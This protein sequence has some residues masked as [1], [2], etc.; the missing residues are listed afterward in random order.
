MKRKE[1]CSDV[2]EGDR[3]EGG[4]GETAERSVLLSE[5]TADRVGVGVLS[6][7]VAPLTVSAS[8]EEMR[9]ARRN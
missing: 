2:V 1:S 3:R 5:V 9:G 8:T 4:E 7:C 6:P